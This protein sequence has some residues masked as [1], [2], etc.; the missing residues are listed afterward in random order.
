MQGK[1]SLDAIPQLVDL[2]PGAHARSS[3]RFIAK[4]FD[5]AL[6]Q[7]AIGVWE[8]SLPDD[9]VRFSDSLFLLLGVDP[10]TGDAP[11]IFWQQRIHPDDRPA[12]DL[13]YA[14]FLQGRTAAFEHSYRARHEEGRWVVLLTR[15]TWVFAGERSQR[16][17]VQGFVVDITQQNADI[18][19]LKLREQRYRMSLSALPG[20]VYETDLRTGR[21]QRHG[22]GRN[23][24][25]EDWIGVS[26]FNEWLQRVHPEDMERVMGV[27]GKHRESGTAYEVTYRIRHPDGHWRQALHRGTYALDHDG[28][29]FRAYGVIEDI[30]NSHAQSEQ[31][32][33]QA[34][35]IERMSE[36]IILIGPDLKIMHANPAMENLLGYTHGALA[37]LSIGSF[38]FRSESAVLEQLN[39]VFKGTENNGTVVIDLECRRRDG[40]MCPLEACFSSM[41]VGAQR[42]LAG[43]VTD[44]SERKRLERELMQIATRV[45][46]RIGSD[47]HDGLGQQLAGIAMMLHGLGQRA[48]K[49]GSNMLK[50]E[51]DD[52]VAL[53]NAAIGSTRTLARGLSPVSPTREGLILGFEELAQHVRDRYGLQIQ[54]ALQ[55]PRELHFGED[56]ATNL[57]RIA[58]EG[59]LNAA[60]HAD[61]RTIRLQVRVVGGELELVVVDDGRGFDLQAHHQGGM[62]L[63]VMRFRAQL[64]GGYLAVES[65]QGGG[66]S[67]ICRCPVQVS[68]AAA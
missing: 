32:Q 6:N 61:A 47:L 37:G 34:N 39:G 58:Q 59:V 63:R 51:V 27:I 25:V 56:T 11:A 57:Y 52:I 55:L 29:A 68:E 4:G 40:T 19:R 67:L 13:A 62:G 50:G 36:G 8:H 54:M 38:S 60:R 45:Q 17:C 42:C 9:A 14:M 26:N 28:K 5:A 41:Q 22:L 64:V 44:T 18:D 1:L 30:T 66:T 2:A 48:S 33:M 53:V 31:L 23:A 35:I 10:A 15:A 20:V 24:Q 46:Q 7:L 12:H 49:S 65:R 16:T 21:I 3:Q 43:L